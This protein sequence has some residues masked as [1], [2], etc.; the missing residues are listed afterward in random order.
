MSFGTL[1]L[2]SSSLT[3]GDECS[4]LEALVRGI[5]SSLV[6][7]YEID[8]GPDFTVW[9]KYFIYYPSHCF[10]AGGFLS[11]REG[12]VTLGHFN[13]WEDEVWV[14]SGLASEQTI[15]PHCYGFCLI[16]YMAFYCSLVL[17]SSFEWAS[18]THDYFR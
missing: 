15:R 12:Q 7:D 9:P 8:S 16:I 3:H 14:Y 5:L 17:C 4:D 1:K 10:S 18:T 11:G 2:Q 13:G 6:T